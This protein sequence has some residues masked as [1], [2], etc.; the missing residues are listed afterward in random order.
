MHHTRAL[1]ASCW[2]LATTVITI[3]ISVEENGFLLKNKIL[4]IIG[5]HIYSSLFTLFTLSE[6][7]QSL[8]IL[9]HL[10]TWPTNKIVANT[11]SSFMIRLHYFLT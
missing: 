4:T 2:Q 7:M 10:L 11:I 5:C 9:S 6:K 3:P 8:F 1:A